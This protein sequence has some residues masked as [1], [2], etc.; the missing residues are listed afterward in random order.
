[1]KAENTND[2]F[3]LFQALHSCLFS[4]PKIRGK[5]V[6]HGSNIIPQPQK[7][8]LRMAED[9]G[10]RMTLGPVG[11]AL[12]HRLPAHQNISPAH[13]ALVWQ[14]FEI[15]LTPARHIVTNSWLTFSISTQF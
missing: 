5:K 3:I 7:R 14:P 11:I 6:D 13:N 12:L 8:H 10:S 2:S 4:S 9:T 1:M 15:I